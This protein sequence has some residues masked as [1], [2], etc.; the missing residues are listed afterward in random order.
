MEQGRHAKGRFARGN[1]FA[2][3]RDLNPRLVEVAGLRPLGRA[4]RKHSPGQIRKLAASLDHFGFVLPI[5]IDPQQRVVAGWGLA[6][7]AK[8]LGL[9]EVPAI[10]LTDLSEPE[11]R[12]LRLGLNRITEDAAWD[13]GELRIELSEILKL[14]PDFEL[15]VTGFEVTEIDRI[16]KGDGPNQQDYVDEVPSIAACYIPVA[17]PGDVWLL[18]RHRLLCGDASMAQS[19]ERL[20]GTEK[21]NMMFA[22]L[23][24]GTPIDDHVAELGA[25]TNGG[26]ATALAEPVPAE[27]LPFLTD[28]FTHAARCSIHGAYHFVCTQ[29]PHA[30]GVM[31]AAEDIYGKPEDVCIWTDNEKGGARAGLRYLSKQAF[32]FVF[33]VAGGADI[34]GA[35]VGR[36]GQNQTDVW[37]HCSPNV[38]DAAAKAKFAPPS[39]TTPVAMLV[40][41]ICDC[42]RPDGVVLDPFA[43]TGT[44]LI[45]AEQTG[46]RARVI[47]SNPMLADLAIERWQRFTDRIAR[48]AETGRP[49][50]RRNHRDQQE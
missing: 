2:I 34:S 42:C 49:F 25:V 8:Q 40:E 29:W 16:L 17:R 28:V 46:R 27:S 37:D 3:A 19:Y 48:H 23:A 35:A 31:L 14:A 20:L 43:K 39:N 7:A 22:D 26:S 32:M 9:T 50:A 12:A 11:L 15:E 6:L 41:V 4:T 13:R 47:E 18:G 38:P 1:G 10:R 5:L 44:T 24:S 45:A 30:N 33:R 21:V 36:R